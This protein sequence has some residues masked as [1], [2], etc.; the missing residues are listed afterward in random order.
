MTFT[1]GVLW[2]LSLVQGCT[3]DCHSES[4]LCGP[5]V[6]IKM[7]SYGGDNTLAPTLVLKDRGIT[8]LAPNGLN[9]SFG[10]KVWTAI[11]LSYNP[12]G[13]LPYFYHPNLT[14]IYAEECGIKEINTSIASYFGDWCVPMSLASPAL[15][16]CVCRG[17]CGR[18]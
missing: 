9:C 4:T 8:A 1:A 3:F 15:L 5:A 6:E 17:W 16:P 2:S 18:C 10:G 12:L 13:A 11:S 7:E 14:Y